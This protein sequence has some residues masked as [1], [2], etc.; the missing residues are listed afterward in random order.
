MSGLSEIKLE[1]NLELPVVAHVLDDEQLVINQG[2]EHGV[3]IGQRFLVYGLGKEIL[4]PRTQR[5]LGVLEIVRGT[6]RVSHL[7]PKMATITTDMTIPGSRTVRKASIFA[8][9]FGP[10]EQLE[11]PVPV[12]FTDPIVGDFAKPI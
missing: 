8:N 9:P 2:R 5:S 3:K 4:D 12:G 11:A 7:Q 6:G 10:E 1:G